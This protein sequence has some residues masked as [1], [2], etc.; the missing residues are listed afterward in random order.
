MNITPKMIL[1]P[2]LKQR[3]INLLHRIIRAMQNPGTQKQPL[4]K[5]SAVKFHGQLTDLLRSEG[6]TNHIIGG[7]VHAVAAIIDALVGKQNLQQGDASAVRREAVTDSRS[8]AVS[9][10]LSIAFS[11]NAAGRTR[12]IILGRIRENIQFFI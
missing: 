6:S 7:T 2:Q 4:N 3:L 11:V 1:F 8:F 5:I 10:M 9:H 12:H